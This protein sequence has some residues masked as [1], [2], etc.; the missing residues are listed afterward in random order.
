[1][2]EEVPT[3]E[4][5][6][7]DVLFSITSYVAEADQAIDLVE[8]ERI[9]VIE[10]HNSDWW[11]VRKHLTDEKGWA[12]AQILMD[13]ENYTLYVQKKLNEK[14]DRLPVFESEYFI[15]Y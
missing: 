3:V 6:E 15:D 12:P 14:I 11:F 7:G 10:R 4:I 13:E 2:I 9:Y 8:G 1:M 5:E